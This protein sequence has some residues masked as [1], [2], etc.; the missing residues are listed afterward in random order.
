MSEPASDDCR[1]DRPDS[2]NAVNLIENSHREDR[3]CSG[4]T[5]PDAVPPSGLEAAGERREPC[6][7]SLQAN[8]ASD[9]R[10]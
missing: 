4:S 8:N 9:L 3:L 10:S 5:V 1:I 7:N 2:H 6:T